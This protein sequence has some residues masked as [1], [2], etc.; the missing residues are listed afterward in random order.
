MKPQRITIEGR[1]FWRYRLLISTMI[2]QAVEKMLATDTEE[3]SVTGKI[4]IRIDKETDEESGEI[5]IKPRF[6]FVA[7]MSVP[8][9]AQEKMDSDGEL[10]LIRG[11]DGKLAICDNQISMDEI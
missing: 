9:K 6:T 3:G 5:I 2:D 10:L 8:V 7:D 1:A 4:G 11:Q